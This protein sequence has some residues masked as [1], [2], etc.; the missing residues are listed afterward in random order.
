MAVMKYG[1]CLS[2]LEMSYAFANAT[3]NPGKIISPNPSREYLK[4]SNEKQ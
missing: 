3:K 2:R 1:R 4:N